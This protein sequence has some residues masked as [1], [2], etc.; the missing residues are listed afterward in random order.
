M[1][2]KRLI[3]PTIT[4]SLCVLP[5]VLFGISWAEILVML[6]IGAGVAAIMIWFEKG[7]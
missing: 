1:S 2:A 4:I 6:G 7:E 5:A 3:Q